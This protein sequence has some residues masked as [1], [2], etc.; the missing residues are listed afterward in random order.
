VSS[1][2][3]EAGAV[4]HA[5]LGQGPR[6][7]FPSADWPDQSSPFAALLDGTSDISVSPPSPPPLPSQK[8]APRQGD[9]GRASDASAP[10]TPPSPPKSS[11]DSAAPEAPTDGVSASQAK[12]SQDTG[13]AD[14]VLALAA[15]D[16]KSAK[17]P[18]PTTGGNLDV[19]ATNGAGDAILAGDAIEAIDAGSTAAATPDSKRDKTSEAEASA[20]DTVAPAAPPVDPSANQPVAVAAPV[21]IPVNAPP[22]PAAA[23]SGGGGNAND[24]A[25]GRDA[26]QLL[27]LGDGMKSGAPGGNTDRVGADATKEGDS[28]PLADT[29]GARPA[30]KPAASPTLL[31]AP[32]SA[33]GDQPTGPSQPNIADGPQARAADAAPPA[34][35]ASNRARQRAASRQPADAAAGSQTDSAVDSNGNSN[36]NIDPNDSNAEAKHDPAASAARIEDIARQALDGTARHIEAPAATTAG[37][38]AAHPLGIEAGNAQ[39]QPDGSG[40]PIAPAI[41]TTSAAPAAPTT[42]PAPNTIP[43]AGLAVE[44]AAQAHAGRNRFEI[45]LDPPELGRIDVRLDVDRDGKVA[46]RLVVDRPETLDILRRDAPQLERSLQQAGLKTADNALQFSLRDHGGFGGQNPYSNHGAPAGA[47]RVVIPDKELPT[48]AAPTAGYGRMIGT[49]AG[50]DIRV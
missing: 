16:K 23:P 45:R 31:R 50:V 49:R 22:I 4:R 41:L 21:V 24:A 15:L 25:S 18:T 5:H 19:S 32:Q 13:S 44:I 14:A 36:P 8:P 7:N 30:A 42:T 6:S 35:A 48:V 28:I 39:S 10:K 33:Q 43:I 3:P 47:A 11:S 20:A 38:G 34:D 12:A 29:V 26:A 40:G 46:S 27:A 1:V 2:T 37:G 17:D 9:D